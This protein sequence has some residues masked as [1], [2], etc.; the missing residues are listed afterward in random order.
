KPDRFP[1]FNQLIQGAISGKDN[2]AALEFVDAG[3]KYDCEHNEGRRR[4]DFELWRGRVLTR[5]GE[6]DP[7]KD[8]FDRLIDRVP[9]DMKF[10]STAAESMLSAKQPA[11][12]LA[13]AQSGLEQARKQQD[14]DSEGHF[15]ELVEAAGR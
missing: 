8:V 1:W 10:R 3:E 7:A 6:I 15:L 13:Y 11:I 2:D 5:R 4:N 12:A 14:R 9:S